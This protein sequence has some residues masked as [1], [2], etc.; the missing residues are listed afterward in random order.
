MKKLLKSKRGEGYID[1]VIIV[2]SA[3][4]VIALAIKVIPVFITKHQL[5]TY[6]T[7]LCRTAEISGRVDSE[8]TIRAQQLTQQTGINPG[9][10][11]TANYILGT[12]EVQLNDN[13]SVVLTYSKDIGLFGSFGSFPVQLTSKATGRSE[14]Y[15]K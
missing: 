8:T 15:W 11:W 3:V 1:S 2:M 5:D 9:I 14:E 7:E 10:T 4:L 6:A 12:N 13:I